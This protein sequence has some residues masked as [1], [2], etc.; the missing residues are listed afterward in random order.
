MRVPQVD[1]GS[2]DLGV[3]PEILCDAARS[4]FS[5]G[6]RAGN[7]G[8]QAAAQRW[9]IAEK[10]A[11]CFQ[12]TGRRASA[13]QGFPKDFKVPLEIYECSCQFPPYRR[14]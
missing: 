8:L 14:R 13:P 7:R 5:H 2:G 1:V 12:T 4:L 3:L 6:V 10:T 11:T 9:T